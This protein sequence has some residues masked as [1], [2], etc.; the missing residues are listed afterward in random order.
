MFWDPIPDPEAKWLYTTAQPITL[1]S[2][3]PNIA[4]NSWLN[5]DIVLLDQEGSIASAS[6]IESSS[7]DEIHI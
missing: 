6:D 7:K 1:P 4:Q 2:S 3:L 5:D